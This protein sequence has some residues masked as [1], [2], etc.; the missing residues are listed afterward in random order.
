MCYSGRRGDGERDADRRGE[1]MKYGVVVRTD[2]DLRLLVELGADAE[3]AGWDGFF[4]WD[5]F[6]GDNPWVL[7][8]GVAARTQRIRLGPMVTPPSRRRPWQ[9]A[10]EAATLDRLSD[11]RAVLPLA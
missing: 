9:L 4:V 1:A 3:A 5:A 8:G 2:I 10:S 6:S 7:L 11:G